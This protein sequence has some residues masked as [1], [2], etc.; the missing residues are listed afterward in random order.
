MPF[1]VAEYNETQSRQI[2]NNIIDLLKLNPVTDKI[3]KTVIPTIQP[4]FE[5]SYR[6]CD[7]NGRATSATSAASLTAVTASSTKDTY[8]NSVF[9]SMSKD[10]TCDASSGVTDVNVTINGSTV[11]ILT[12]AHQ[13]TTALQDTVSINFPVPV[14]IDRGTTVRATMPT[15]TAGACRVAIGATCFTLDAN[16]TLTTS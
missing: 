13:T 3:P 4:V 6:N 12:L 10:A 11:Q 1:N 2:V 5:V 15:F 8:L 7:L 9:I 16:S 14:K